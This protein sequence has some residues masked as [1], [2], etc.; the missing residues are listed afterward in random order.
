LTTCAIRNLSVTG[1]APEGKAQLPHR[2][3]PWHIAPNCDAALPATLILKRDV[4]IRQRWQLFAPKCAR[5]AAAERLAKRSVD[6]ALQ[7]ADHGAP[8][9]YLSS[10]PVRAHETRRSSQ[11]RRQVMAQVARRTSKQ[12]PIARV[13]KTGIYRG[14]F[15]TAEHAR[16]LD[17]V[18]LKKARKAV[19]QVGT[20]SVRGM[21][22]PISAEVRNGMIESLRP[23]D[24]KHCASLPRHSKGSPAQ[25]RSA[26]RAALSKVLE[27]KLK[28]LKLPK[29]VERLRIP[30][31][32]VVITIITDW[33]IC[34]SIE[35][36]DGV[37]CCFCSSSGSF[38]L[39]P[40]PPDSP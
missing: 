18:A 19:F 13:G 28:T 4:Q 7:G 2:R 8:V 9:Y 25:R 20:V 26:T 27:L 10:L 23:T 21:E 29:P 31:W 17:F 38:C 3:G 16:Y 37:I 14:R 30:I 22:I 5:A 15:R 1:R 39:H 6:D 35:Y 32:G 12:N 24:C 40:D 36:T 34:L 11:Q 33:E